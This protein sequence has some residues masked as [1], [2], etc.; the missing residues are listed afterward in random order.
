M[1]H[2][3]DYREKCLRLASSDCSLIGGTVTE[4]IMFLCSLWGKEP[5]V[6]QEDRAA[7]DMWQTE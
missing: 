4:E 6:F 3:F 1:Q 7:L 2:V 5:S